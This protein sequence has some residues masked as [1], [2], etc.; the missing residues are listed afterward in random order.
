MTLLIVGT[1]RVSG[2]GQS[3][4]VV[5]VDLEPDA[6]AWARRAFGELDSV[7][8]VAGAPIAAVTADDLR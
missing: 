7:A 6:L 2:L 8:I 5:C 3:S 1:G 4:P